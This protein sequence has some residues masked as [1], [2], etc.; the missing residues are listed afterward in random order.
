MSDDFVEYGEA[1]K[2]D[3]PAVTSTCPGKPLIYTLD[4]QGV[5]IVQPKCVKLSLDVKILFIA[6]SCLNEV[7]SG[8]TQLNVGVKH[9]S[10]DSPGDLF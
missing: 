4:A 9:E 1:I 3:L 8:Q 6:T 2:V 10:K 5:D 7:P